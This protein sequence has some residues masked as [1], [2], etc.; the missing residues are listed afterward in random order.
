MCTLERKRKNINTAGKGK[1]E[2][3]QSVGPI[4]VL[5]ATD[6]YTKKETKRN[7]AGEGVREYHR[8][9]SVGPILVLAATDMYAGKIKNRCLATG[10][11]LG[12]GRDCEWM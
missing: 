11:L 9:G 8:G 10:A 5:A 3:A 6:M 2:L 4:H 12:R 7:T 1:D